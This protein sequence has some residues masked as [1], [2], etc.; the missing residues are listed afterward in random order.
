[1]NAVKPPVSSCSSRSR[2]RCSRRS[3]IGLDRAVHH[4]RRRAQAGAVRVAHHVEPL[5]GRRLAVAVQQLAHAIDEDLGAAAG[6]AVEAGVD[7][8]LDDLRHRQ[9]REPRDVDHFGRRQRVQPERRIA[10]LHRPEQILV[11]LQRQVRVVA[12][13]QQQLPAA[14]R[15]R[16]VDLPEDL[17]EPE[18]VAVGRADR[19]VERAEVA[20]RDAD[21]RVVD[22]AIDDVGDDALGMLAG[23]DAVGEP[24]R[25]AAVGAR[26]YSSSASCRSTR[27]PLQNLRSRDRLDRH[28]RHRSETTS[29]DASGLSPR[30]A[31]GAQR[32]RRTRRRPACSRSPSAY[33][34]LSLK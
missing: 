24:A 25:A 10:R 29:E 15:D 27:P 17:V 23:A 12:A 9:L 2:N 5:V 14:E 30:P 34:I 8:P 22:V 4:R 26:R 21:V 18:H 13:L 32:A 20:P 31:R 33:R 7:Q 1:M 19:A 11:P 6:N 28:S 16:L 3:S